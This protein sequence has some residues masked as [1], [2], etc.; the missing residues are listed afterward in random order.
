MENYYK[1]CLYSK[2]L[3][4]LKIFFFLTYNDVKSYE[5]KII[6]GDTIHL[7]GE[8]I[9][10]TYLKEPN[11][12]GDKVIGML[13]ELP[14]EFGLKK[15]IDYDLQFEKAYLDPL[16]NVLNVIGW[17]YEKQTSLEDFFV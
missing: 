10:F 6:D 9:R 3:I 2:N 8:K 5:I 1:S 17:N 11:P 12:V 13:T 4:F 16:K 15:Y 7:N 14:T